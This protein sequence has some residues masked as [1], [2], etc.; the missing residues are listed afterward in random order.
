MGALD[1]AITHAES[2]HQDPIKHGEL[3]FTHEHLELYKAMQYFFNVRSLHI[4][5]KTPLG[6][7]C[8]FFCRS[9]ASEP[10]FRSYN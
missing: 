9:S 8:F 10:P 6:L 1:R 3:D 5:M 4:L 7:I 2:V